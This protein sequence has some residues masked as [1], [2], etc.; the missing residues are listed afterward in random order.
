MCFSFKC[1][2]WLLLLLV[3]ELYWCAGGGEFT[4]DNNGL[5]KCPSR[6]NGPIQPY[7]VANWAIGTIYVDGG[8][9]PPTWQPSSRTT[10]LWV[11][12]WFE[13]TQPLDNTTKNGAS[14]TT[15]CARWRCSFIVCCCFVYCE[16]ASE[17]PFDSGKWSLYQTI[18]FLLY[19]SLFFHL[20][21]SSILNL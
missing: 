9:L 13:Q 3:I 5:M 2:I 7:T 19:F 20:F 21:V 10:P 17:Q 14:V 1:R 18:W 15:T 8:G 12:L 16:E 4:V 11:L 6:F